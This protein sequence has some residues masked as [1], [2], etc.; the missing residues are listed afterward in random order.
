V[1]RRRLKI[2]RDNSFEIDEINDSYNHNCH[3]EDTK[4]KID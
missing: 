1:E 2:G 4:T 3:N